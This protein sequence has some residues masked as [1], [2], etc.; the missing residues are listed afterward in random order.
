M[1]ASTGTRS[2]RGS[3]R[4]S[5]NEGPQA[6]QSGQARVVEND[7]EENC[8]LPPSPKRS[9]DSRPWN[10]TLYLSISGRHAARHTADLGGTRQVTLVVNTASECGYTPQA[11]DGEVHRE[12]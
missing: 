2:S 3:T 10:N 9:S 7:D 6:A 8:A 5:K 12:M 1:A 4:S 11:R